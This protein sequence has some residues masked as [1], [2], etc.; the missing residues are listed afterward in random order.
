MCVPRLI[1]H[2]LAY[3]R[4]P[5]YFQPLH[6]FASLC[7]RGC[8]REPEGLWDVLVIK[9]TV[10]KRMF[11]TFSSGQR[12]SVQHKELETDAAQAML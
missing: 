9:A 7:G 11:S 4:M 5:V 6:L 1:P 2:L 12:D 10:V 3:P 8:T